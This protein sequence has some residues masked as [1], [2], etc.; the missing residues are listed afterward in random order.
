M[1]TIMNSLLLDSLM[2]R[3]VQTERGYLAHENGYQ[4]TDEQLAN[5]NAAL[6]L[7]KDKD[8]RPYCLRCDV[9]PRVALRAYGFECWHCKNQFGF[10]LQKISEVSP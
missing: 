4:M 8:Y 10:D 2:A 1:S 9:M 7:K 6:G 5:L 3:A